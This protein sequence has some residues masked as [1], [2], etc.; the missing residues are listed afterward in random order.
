VS[1][2]IEREPLDALVADVAATRHC[3]SVAWG[4][5][6]D[7]R[8]AVHGAAGTV[9]D[10]APDERTVYRIASM[11]K[12]FS[13]AVTLLLRDEGVLGLDD[14]IGRHAPELAGLRSATDDAPP[15]TVR[16]LLC[17][18]SGLVGDDPWADRHLDLSDDQFDAMVA[19]GLVFAHS[20][21]SCF[22]Y[23]N[24]GFA[25]LGRVIHRATGMRLQEH[26][27]ERLLEPLGMSDTT[28]S[29]PDHD[30]WA[31]PWRRVD[32]GWI[33]ESDP[34]PD[35]L[36]APM[37]GIW[38]TVADLATWVTW[39][40]AAFPAR[41]DD[42]PGPLRRSSRREMQTPQR[43][44]GLRTLRDLRV[45]TSYGYGTL[46]L[47]EPEHGTVVG[48]SGGL[49]GYGSNMRWTPGGAIGV[50]ALSNVTYAPMTELAARVHDLVVDQGAVSRHERT[51]TSELVALAEALLAVLDAWAIGAPIDDDELARVF[52]DNVAPDDDFTRRAARV[53]A[54]GHLTVG[55][56]I[57]TS[58]AAAEIRCTTAEGTDATVSFVLAP[59]GPARIQ[60]FDV[61]SNPSTV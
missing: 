57:A 34:L 26:V 3:P 2:A 37:G 53:A 1:T 24:F 58:D 59:V 7:G 19:D 36:V 39:L 42:D 23:S 14:P 18:S 8:L 27:S 5:V 33:E 17:M 32:D 22:E 50:I 55:T 29:R 54:H 6:L 40:A 48:H 21:G 46:I 38:T 61:Q 9:Q 60:S 52:A 25:L 51:P 11:T 15:I 45:P 12:S 47:D 4:V 20:T 31:R 13:A 30:R 49:P 41:D 44:A 35:G 28:W 56:L 10:V 16:D 43:Y